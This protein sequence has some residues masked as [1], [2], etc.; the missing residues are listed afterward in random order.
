VQNGVLP[1]ALPDEAVRTLCRQ[2]EAQP[3]AQVTIDLA[4]QE[5]TGPDGTLYGF[6]IATTRKTLL[7]EGLDEIGLTLKHADAIAGFE[8]DYRAKLPWLRTA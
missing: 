2:L 7:L 3:G 5:V 8:R 1:V 6:D 4:R